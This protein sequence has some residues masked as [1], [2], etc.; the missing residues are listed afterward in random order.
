[1][2][3]DYD[4]ATMTDHFNGIPPVQRL[5]V[6]LIRT[7]QRFLSPLLPPSCRFYPTCSQYA[8]DAITTHGAIRGGWLAVRRILRCHPFHPGGFDPVIK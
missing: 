1:M 6:K 4:T 5:F 2:H 8:I 3:H 7:Y